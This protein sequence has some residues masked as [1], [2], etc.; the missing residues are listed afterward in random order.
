M[1]NKNN[2]NF[3]EINTIIE[4]VSNITALTKRRIAQDQANNVDQKV[5]EGKLPVSARIEATLTKNQTEIEV[6]KV[7]N[8]NNSSQIAPGVG[9]TKKGTDAMGAPITEDVTYNKIPEKNLLDPANNL[10]SKTLENKEITGVYKQGLGQ[11]S[12]VLQ[13]AGSLSFLYTGSA[14]DLM[15]EIVETGNTPEILKGDP[16][17]ESIVAK[18][19]FSIKQYTKGK[20]VEQQKK[21]LLVLKTQLREIL[22]NKKI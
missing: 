22:N 12:K 5:K 20:N 9:K 21:N 1:E 11:G 6:Q 15:K 3:T 10:D 18:I 19:K 4:Q 16:K 8:K 14:G 13:T 2:L 17:A 7:L